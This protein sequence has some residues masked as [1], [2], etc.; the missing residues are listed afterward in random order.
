MSLLEPY[1]TK[2]IP[3]S[4]GRTHFVSIQKLSCDLWQDGLS[5]TL[6]E[7]LHGKR[8][9]MLCDAH[10]REA[11][12]A[13]LADYL[14]ENGWNLTVREYRHEDLVNNEP[15]V[16]T[17]VLDMSPEITG[18]LAVGGGTMTDLGRFVASRL[19]RPF[20]LVMT[21][22]SMDGYASNVAGMMIGGKKRVLKD[23]EYPA[24]VLGDLE[25]IRNAPMDLIRS[26]YGDM[27]GKRTALPDWILAH[28]MH[29][30]Y[31]CP[32]TAGLVAQSA[33][34]CADPDAVA[35]LMARDAGW[36]Q[37]LT[38][39]LLLTGVNMALCDDT[40]PASG[41]EHIFSHYL[42]EQA[43]DAGRKPPS[44]GASVG[45][46]TLV[47]TLLYEYLF[48]AAPSELKELE[49]E[50]RRSLLPSQTV[51]QLLEQS[52]IGG[53]LTDY[54]AD[55]AALAAMIQASSGPN[56]RYTIL[57]YLQEHKQLDDAIEFVC[58]N[59]KER[60]QAS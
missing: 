22:P 29:G 51:Y 14:K 45:F 24:A 55:T 23:C 44:H 27:L 59:M 36:I 47:S 18:I 5:D 2:Q 17:A 11:I 30:D 33:S 25:V 4:C 57:A 10:T 50:L 49:P 19:G 53:N 52:G 8:V 20:V 39:S 31:Y 28:H 26:G 3:C 15:V 6:A 40:R 46:G 42:V 56:K 38:E 12:N 16:G 37:T 54:L 21:C 7:L 34:W 35:A 43:I 32:L 60:R 48:S 9:L 58:S 41:S 13:P 1:L